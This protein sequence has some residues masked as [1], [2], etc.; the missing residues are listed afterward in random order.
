MTQKIR[1]CLVVWLEKSCLI[2]VSLSKDC[3]LPDE[4]WLPNTVEENNLKTLKSVNLLYGKETNAE[5]TIQK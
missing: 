1:A 5:G 4:K 2:T 3:T